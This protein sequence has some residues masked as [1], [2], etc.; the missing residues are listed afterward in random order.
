MSPTSEI[1]RDLNDAEIL[2]RMQRDTYQKYHRNVAEARKRA[3]KYKEQR[4]CTR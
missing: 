1:A 3:E 4:L 2:R